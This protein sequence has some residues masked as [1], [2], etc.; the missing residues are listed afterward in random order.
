MTQ[1]NKLEQV[2]SFLKDKQGY[3]K[4]GGERLRSVLLRHGIFANTDTCKQAIKE[5]NQELKSP[6]VEG[7]E[8]PKILIYDIETSYLIAKSWRIGWDI[9]LNHEDIISPK[10]I[11][12]IS[13][14]WLDE[15]QVYTLTWDK[16][17]D[18]KFMLEQFIEVM[19]E[20]DMLVAHNGDKFDLRWIKTRAILNGL[21][22]LP[23]YNQF[24]TLK[25]AKKKFNFDSNKL[26][27]L[28]KDLG[29]GEKIKTE[30]G[31]WDAVILQKDKEALIRMC[32]YCE[33]DV[34]LL[35]GVY[36]KLANWELPK[37]HHGVMNGKSPLTSPISGGNRLELVKT[38][39]TNKGTIKHIMKDLDTDRLFEMSDSNLKKYNKVDSEE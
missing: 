15:D 28:G 39:T 9:Q 11:I 26:N 12:C 35:E 16:N 32:A 25:V 30:L 10:K 33:Q 17:Q 24:D 23:N 8:N 20:A 29:L 13:Y 38:V 5:V 22:M 18:D 31:L 37:Y 36:K 4:E 34:R 3:L 7:I 6:S 2:K 1:Q 19:N 14:K 27:N 21:T